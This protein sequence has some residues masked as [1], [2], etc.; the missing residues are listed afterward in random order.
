MNYRNKTTGVV[1]TQ[2]EIRRANSNTSFPRVWDADV[3]THLNVDP[4]LAAPQPSHTALQQVNSV[5]P[6]QDSLN[7]WVEGWAVV[8][9]FSATTDDDGV[10]TS[11]ADHEAAYTA[12]ELAKVAAAAREKRD[13]LL[14]ATD[15]YALSDVVMTSD[16]TTY[17]SDLRSVPTLSGFP[18][19]FEWPT[20]P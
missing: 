20:A 4:V 7:N 10:T 9:K 19:D 2:G 1:S 13:A 6:V 15:F 8:D 12:S 3:C 16:M 14:A 17:R 5:A 11:K 18:N